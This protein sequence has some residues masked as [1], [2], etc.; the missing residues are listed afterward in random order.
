MKRKTI[1]QWVCSQPFQKCWNYYYLNKLMVIC[2]INSQSIL[3]VF[4]KN[5]RNDLLVM[6]EK[7]KTILNKKMIVGSLFMGL[8]KP[9]DTLDREVGGGRWLAHLVSRFTCNTTVI[10]DAISSPPVALNLNNLKPS[11][12]SKTISISTI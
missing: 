8:S 9:F 10:V 3:Q 1:A 4:E 6:I 11:K 2:Q 5:H 7:W 12:P